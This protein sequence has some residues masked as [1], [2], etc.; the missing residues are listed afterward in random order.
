MALQK[1]L[2]ERGRPRTDGDDDVVVVLD[3]LEEGVELARIYPLRSPV[4]REH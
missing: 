1:T 3:V 2:A 4:P